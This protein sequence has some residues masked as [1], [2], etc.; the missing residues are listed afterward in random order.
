MAPPVLLFLPWFRP[1]SAFLTQ[2]VPDCL[3]G[4]QP[5]PAD[6]DSLNFALAKKP[7]NIAGSETTDPG[8]LR[9]RD[10]L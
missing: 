3:L 2:V 4:R 6:L 7:A 8:G 5:V 9:D 10:K 1:W